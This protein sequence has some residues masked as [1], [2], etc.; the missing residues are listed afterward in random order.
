[1]AILWSTAENYNKYRFD[2]TGR[3]N[4]FKFVNNLKLIIVKY[5]LNFYFSEKALE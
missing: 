4:W 3:F 1:M 2:H 5:N